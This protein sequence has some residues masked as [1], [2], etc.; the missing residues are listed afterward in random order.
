MPNGQLMAKEF[1]PNEI[2]T[3][4]NSVIT[5]EQFTAR[6]GSD[7]WI[8]IVHDEHSN[9]DDCLHPANASEVGVLPIH[10]WNMPASS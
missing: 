4:M 9:L 8:D 3:Q 1:H 5:K 2:K 7:W 10:H 6:N